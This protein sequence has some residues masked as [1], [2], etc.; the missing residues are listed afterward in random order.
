VLSPI[1]LRAHAGL[2]SI[3]DASDPARCGGTAV[4]LATLQRIGVAIPAAKCLTTDFYHLW[5]EDSGLEPVLTELVEAV[6]AGHDPREILAAIRRRIQVTPISRE[7]EAALRAGVASLVSGRD[8][9]LT[10]RPSGVGEDRRDVSHAGGHASIV[11]PG[12]DT[13]ALIAAIKRCWVSLWT[14]TAWAYRERLSIPHTAAAMAVVVQRFVKAV[15]S[16]VAFSADLVTSD[17]TTIVVEAGWGAGAVLAA[18]TMTPDEYRLPSNGDGRPTVRRRPG[19]QTTLMVWRAG[20][21]TTV[22][23]DAAQRHRPVLRNSQVRELIGI[24]KGIERALRVPMNVEWLSDGARFWVVQARPITALATASRSP[25]SR[26]QLW[27]RA[28][29]KEI[30]PE[31][32]SPLALSYLKRSLNRMFRTYHAGHG[33]VLPPGASLV[34]VIHGRPYLNLSLMEQLTAERGGDPAIVNRLFGGAS[35]TAAGAPPAAA[36]RG[37]PVTGRARIIREMLTTLC[38]TRYRGGRLF[39][40]LRGLAA[41]LDRTSLPALDDRGLGSHLERF[42]AVLLRDSTLR[43]LHEVV[44]APSRA[45]MILE[46]LLSRWAPTEA[47]LTKPLMTGVGS[48]PTMRMTHRVV[49]LAVAAAQDDRARAY[50]MAD[51]DDEAVRGYE[52]ALAATTV[53]AEL[54]AFVQEFGHRGPYESDVMSLRFA[55]D[56]WPLL[57]LIQLHVRAG[58]RQDAARR[59]AD[60]AHV[61]ST[62][63]VVI[64]RMLRQRYGGLGFVARWTAFRVVCNALQHALAVRDECRHVTTMMVA[65]LRHLVLEVGERARR[66]GSLRDRTD[67]FFLTWDEVPRLLTE[68]DRAWGTLAANR[69]HQR[70]RDAQVNAPDIVV[71]DGTADHIDRKADTLGAGELRGYGV[72]PGV[73]SGRIRVVR[74][75]GMIGH[76]SGEIVVL[77]AIEPTLTP[78]FPLVRGFIAETGGLLS[79]AAIVARE[80]GLPAVV[81]VRDATHQLRDG[82]Q[83]ELDGTTGLIRVLER[84]G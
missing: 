63:M 41:V 19:R 70:E 28:D 3:V 51:L 72:S 55:E 60:R 21:L 65:H 45:Y 33:H 10:V 57:R 37:L 12:H 54:R 30:F 14:E 11:V 22:R 78:I 64:R 16:G 13:Q 68:R 38:T 71:D 6:G 48:L 82:D 80:Y 52:A 84:R 66:A 67:V 73:V 39:R 76:L 50:F 69:R 26:P 58:A 4:G 56:P 35:P 81:N 74:S 25:A 62:A 34:S 49:D 79:D 43:R 46:E 5:L 15:C 20:Q 42:G 7:L 77:P 59:A 47:Q 36:D 29:L 18:E 24:L 9:L 53:L 32:P 2:I 40:R 31:L 17:R 1:A 83:V 44:S 27:T 61:R 75:I 8:G 23:L